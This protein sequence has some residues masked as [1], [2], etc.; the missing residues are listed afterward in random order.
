[1]ARVNEIHAELGQSAQHDNGTYPSICINEN[2]IVVQVNNSAGLLNYVW[3]HVGKV[4]AGGISWGDPV[5][6]DVGRYPRV[7][8]ND[9]GTVVEVH[10]AQFLRDIYYRVGVV[11]TFKQKIKWGDGHCYD[12]GLAPAVA[13]LDNNTVI[14]VHQT[15]AF[16]SYTTYYRLGTVD[17]EHKNIK[18]G[19]SVSYG[20]G[21]ELALTARQDT[22]VELHKST[23][24]NRLRYRV[25]N[26][27]REAQIVAW[28]E[29]TY[30]DDG[31]N[32]SAGLNSNGHLLEVH[33]STILRRLYCRV[34]VVDTRTQT[35]G[36]LRDSAQYDVGTYP[37]VCL[38]DSDDKSIVEAHETN[39]GISIWCRTG[40]LKPSD[41]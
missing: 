40:T 20:R 30:Y 21:R 19:N 35:I 2:N 31:C 18:W 28:G 14:S 7:T 24:G 34:G 4:E 9:H 17:A 32:P 11:D 5:C 8:I 10:E 38:N 3:C 1:M 39:V 41:V 33:T 27:Q 25:G 26:F 6:Y 15:S 29:D 13:F 22:V 36:W 16:G 12:S 37:S 23:W